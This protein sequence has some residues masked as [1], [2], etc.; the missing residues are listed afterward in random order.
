[1][2]HD[3]KQTALNPGSLIDGP[4]RKCLS[5]VGTELSAGTKQS[6]SL[7]KS[8]SVLMNVPNQATSPARSA[9]NKTVGKQLQI[10]SRPPRSS[11]DT[12]VLLLCVS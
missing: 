10:Q 3:N 6:T 1:M 8:P 2:V 5:N 12:P 4:A 9:P 7:V 11:L